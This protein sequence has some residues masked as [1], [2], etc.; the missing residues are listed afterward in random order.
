[1]NSFVRFSACT[2]IAVLT[3]FFTPCVNAD[4]MG[5]QSDYAPANWTQALGTG[6]IDDFSDIPDSIY[7]T[8]GNDPGSVPMPSNTDYTITMSNAG[9]V[10]FSWEY[11]S[12][13][14]GIDASPDYDPFGYLLNN[15][16][17]QLTTDN[18]SDLMQSGSVTL[19]G[20]LVG[21]VFGWR[22]STDENS[23]G[24]ATTKITLFSGPGSPVSSVPEPATASLLGIAVLTG[25]FWQFFKRRRPVATA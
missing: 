9:T 17:V 16:F 8:S 24:S 22:Q 10:M 6:S 13:E 15:N 18:Q 23:N 25:A 3:L 21:D 14:T 2:A 11:K 7:L 5:F 12:S 20:L 4:I 1:M 19:A